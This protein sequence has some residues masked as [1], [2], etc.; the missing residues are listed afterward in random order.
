MFVCNPPQ[1]QV[2]CSGGLGRASFGLTTR[3]ARWPPLGCLPRHAAGWPPSEAPTRACWAPSSGPT[4]AAWSGA[5]AGCRAAGGTW[6]DKTPA[7]GV[8][9]EMGKS[10]GKIRSEHVRVG[11]DRAGGRAKRL[12][13]LARGC[14]QRREPP[15]VQRAACC[16]RAAHLRNASMAVVHRCMPST[17]SRRALRPSR[18]SSQPACWPNR[19]STSDA[20][21][22]WVHGVWV[23]LGG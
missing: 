10:G 22:G 11:R 20:G 16:G 9:G 4:A 2:L 1:K 14:L 21:V 5:G 17:G 18:S 7:R 6:S 23:G 19:A 3:V 13:R 8:C 12:R 15:A